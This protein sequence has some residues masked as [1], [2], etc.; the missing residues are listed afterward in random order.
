M[1]Y[2]KIIRNY[3]SIINLMTPTRLTNV[4]CDPFNIIIIVIIN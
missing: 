4:R 1:F 3:I 2:A